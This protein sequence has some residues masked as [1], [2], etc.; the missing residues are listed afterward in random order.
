MADKP[1]TTRRRDKKK[2]QRNDADV[3]PQTESSSDS[4]GE[5]DDE[6]IYVHN[7]PVLV[8][9]SESD[10][11]QPASPQAPTE[12]F[13]GTPRGEGTGNDVLDDILAELKLQV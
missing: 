3:T 2:P 5:D 10:T 11:E 13:I 6:P 4:Y 8:H 12:H 1:I 7:S 9:G